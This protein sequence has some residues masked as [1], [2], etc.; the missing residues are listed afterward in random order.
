MMNMQRKNNKKT[1]AKTDF[2]SKESHIQQLHQI[3]KN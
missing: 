1:K 3:L 2:I